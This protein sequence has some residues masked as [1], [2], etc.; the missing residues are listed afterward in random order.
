M[1]RILACKVD[2]LAD[3]QALTV[4]GPP[5]IALFRVDGGFYATDDL[6]TH[7]DWS[8]GED[9]ELDGFEVECCLHTARFDVRTGAATQFPAT[10]PLRT[11]PVHVEDGAVWVEVP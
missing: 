8:L 3:G 5:A 9:G 11:Y 2:D 1:A 10:E 7:E 6:C 4:A